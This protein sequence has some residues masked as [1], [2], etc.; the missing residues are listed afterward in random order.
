M[1]Y[2]LFSFWQNLDDNLSIAPSIC[3]YRRIY[4]YLYMYVYMYI[5]VLL[6]LSL[7]WS[8]FPHP[9]IYVYRNMIEI[10]GKLDKSNT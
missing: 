1:K 3:M 8:L 6:V 4:M 2:L 5:W 9:Q 10:C 7:N